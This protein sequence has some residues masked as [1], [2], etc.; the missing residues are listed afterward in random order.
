[1]SLRSFKFWWGGDDSSRLD[2]GGI[3]GIIRRARVMPVSVQ[4]RLWV[5]TGLAT[6]HS[7]QGIQHRVLRRLLRR[8]GIRAQ[9]AA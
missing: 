9:A 5:S 7:P 2:S 6:R 1:M 4:Q 3:K 8:S